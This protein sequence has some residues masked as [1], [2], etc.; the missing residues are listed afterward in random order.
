MTKR[1][2]TVLTFSLFILPAMA[3][4]A[5][6][7]F[8][9]QQQQA[10]Q[11]HMQQQKTENQQ[12]RDSLKGMTPEQRQAAIAAHRQQQ[13]QENLSFRKDLAANARTNLQT[14][15]A[16]NTKLTQAQKDEILKA[17]DDNVNARQ[18]FRA[19]QY[20]ENADY[21]NQLAA[22]TTLT[23][24]Q[25]R[26]DIIQHFSQQRAEN[27]KFAQD[28]RKIMR[29]ERKDIK[30]QGQQTAPAPAATTSAPVVPA[31]TTAP[32]PVTPAPV[33]PATTVQ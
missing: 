4:A 14:K 24:A 22:N 13:Q 27:K 5:D 17:F 20:Q 18:Q 6:N 10:V 25:K 26:A 3:F 21:L 15:L 8:R 16:A 1:T 23:P 32:A 19:S 28:Q 31:T 29:Q 11:Q 33:S 30:A 2:L 9:Q 12:F 7:T